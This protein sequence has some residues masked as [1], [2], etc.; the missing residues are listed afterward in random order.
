GIARVELVIAQ[1][2]PVRPPGSPA[3]DEDLGAI[4]QREQLFVQ[5]PVVEIE[6]DAALAAIEDRDGFWRAPPQ[7]ISAGW[8]HPHDVGAI[9][10][11]HPGGAW[12]GRP[13]GAVDHPESLD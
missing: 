13:A 7:R 8:F 11:E 5:R 2:E 10:G 1:P 9:V 12:S 6:L 3:L 4:D